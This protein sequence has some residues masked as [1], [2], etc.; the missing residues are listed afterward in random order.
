[1][2]ISVSTCID[3][4]VQQYVFFVQE[5][6]DIASILQGLNEH[7]TKLV[8]AVVAEQKFTGKAKSSVSVPLLKEDGSIVHF[9][10]VGLGAKKDFEIVRRAVGS[11][12]KGAQ[13]KKIKTVSFALQQVIDCGYSVSTSEIA[14]QVTTIA[15]M[16]GY[17]FDRYMSDAKDSLK[18]MAVELC[19]D[20]TVQAE[21]SSGI[22]Q[23]IIIADAVNTAR[24]WIDM[25]PSDLVPTDVANVVQKLA[26]EY[27][28]TCKVFDKKK[29]E[30]LKMGGLLGVAR[31]S[32]QD[33]RFITLEYMA[34][35]GGKVI[36]LVGK[37][38]TF[39]S[40]GL[41]LKPANSM[42]NMKED[43]AGAACVM[44]TVFALARLKVKANVVA[45]APVTENMISGSAT[46]PGDVLTF[47]NGKTAE[48][49]NTDA[50]GRLILADALS[51]TVDVYK[52]AV[53]IDV[54]TLTGAC[55]YA[56]GPYFT[57]LISEHDEV[58]QDLVAAGK[59]S[60]DVVWQLPYTD[61]YKAAIKSRIAD[62]ANISTNYNKAGTITAAAFLQHFVGDVPWAHLDIA[63]S[64]F[65]IKDISYYDS[66]ATGTSVRLLIDYVRNQK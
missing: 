40:G 23:G 32:V 15:I 41:S 61:D 19:A 64:S 16:A 51:Y 7:D 47:Y 38:I 56:V 31:A 9:I 24:E 37:G 13:S 4:A 50:E 52:P 59:Q 29:I 45:V 18:E 46:K 48:V 66:G 14:S 10:L 42:E 54:A 35:P 55:D 36:A 26:Q 58:V 5:K 60:G 1:M 57:A 43:M 28:V 3:K 53:M 63:S 27:G 21:I 65:G 25:P 8:H 12:I 11:V 34:N 39:D 2:K 49:L 17:K 22:E 6:Q 33:P 30:E 44:N 62:I 20:K